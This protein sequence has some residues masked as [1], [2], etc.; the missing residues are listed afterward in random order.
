M[1]DCR[2]GTRCPKCK[3][4][5]VKR[6]GD[7]C[8]PCQS[9][10]Y[11]EVCGKYSL[12]LY[13]KWTRLKAQ[14]HPRFDPDQ[15][16]RCGALGKTN[17]YHYCERC[18]GDKVTNREVLHCDDCYHKTPNVCSECKNITD[19]L[20][21]GNK[22][23]SCY[24]G[25]GWEE[26]DNMRRSNCILCGTSA[27]VD[28]DGF[29]KKCYTDAMERST[30]SGKIHRCAMCRENWVPN[31]VIY[32]SS[33]SSRA[34]PCAECGEKFV[35]TQNAQVLC[36]KCLPKCS[37]CKT[38]FVPLDRNDRFC[39]ACAN[40]IIKGQCLK[41]GRLDLLGMDFNGHC[42]DCSMRDVDYDSSTFVMGYPCIMCGNAQVQDPRD[43]C[44]NCKQK[45]YTCPLCK[46]NKIS[47]REYT[48]Q[49]CAT[50]YKSSA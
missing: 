45:E 41:C 39:S 4:N 27:F 43:T 9:D 25:Q 35:P 44:D 34:K 12:R 40:S 49:S 5:F 18:N 28:D 7:V 42:H 16:S 10:A 22:C 2:C 48:C 37:G 21:E 31:D 20:T 8:E 11:C 50:N 24:Y 6:L 19:V 17:I 30:G 38:K 47:Y 23:P 32:C 33:C 29:C 15:C 3:T 36:A 14:F 1:P 13:P 46:K 26:R